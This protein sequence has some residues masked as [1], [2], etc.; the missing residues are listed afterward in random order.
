MADTVIPRYESQAGFIYEEEFAPDP[1][2]LNYARRACGIT[3]FIA[4][5]ALVAGFFFT[6]DAGLLASGAVVGTAAL[7]LALLFSA[8]QSRQ[9]RRNGVIC[10]CPM[11]SGE[12]HF[13]L[14]A[15]ALEKVQARVAESTEE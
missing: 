5:L 10:S 14:D 8:L 6:I 9:R 2:H 1:H 4:L 11:L 3:F 12:E 7:A 13:H 15:E